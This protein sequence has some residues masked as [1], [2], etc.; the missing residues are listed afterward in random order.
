[1]SVII[2]G[3]DEYELRGEEM[4]SIM[5]KLSVYQRIVS[6]LN[7]MNIWEEMLYFLLERNNFV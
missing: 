4:V 6:Y 7:R 1:M 3:E 5:E 2:H